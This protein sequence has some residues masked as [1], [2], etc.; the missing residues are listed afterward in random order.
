[1]NHD[2]LS[3]LLT[4]SIWSYIIISPLIHNSI[5]III[6]LYIYITTMIITTIIITTLSLTTDHYPFLGAESS[7]R[8]RVIGVS[9]VTGVTRTSSPFWAWTSCLRRT[10]W[11][12]RVPARRGRRGRCFGR[13]EVRDAWRMILIWMENDMLLIWFDID[14]IIWYDRIW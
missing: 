7:P 5:M 6:W 13:G 11:R 4:I 8:L 9:G 2:F 12:W 1:M 14:Y 3:P 10:S